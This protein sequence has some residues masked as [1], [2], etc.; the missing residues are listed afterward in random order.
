[1]LFFRAGAR[2]MRA[3][4]LAH[5][6]N[7]LPAIEAYGLPPGAHGYRLAD[8]VCTPGRRD[9]WVAEGAYSQSAVAL[10]A[11]GVFEYRSK[12]AR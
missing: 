4:T 11:S 9:P 1:M 3:M 7:Q 8:L 12:A 5:A 2:K 10:V 6:Q